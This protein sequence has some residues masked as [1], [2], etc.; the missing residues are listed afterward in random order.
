MR[1]ALFVATVIVFVTAIVFQ[2]PAAVDSKTNAGDL[3]ASTMYPSEIAA[4]DDLVD[5]VL[6]ARDFARSVERETAFLEFDNKTGRFVR[7]QLY[8]YAYDFQGTNLA[9]PF[10]PDF[11][12]RNKSNL[13]DPNGVAFIRDLADN[14]RKGT[15]F[16]YFIFPNPDHGGKDELKIGYVAKVDDSWWLGSGIYLSEVPAF[17]SPDARNDLVFF[18]NEALNYTQKNGKDKAIEAFND[19]NGSFVRGNLY[20]YAYDTNGT[21]LALP[22]QPELVSKSRLLAEDPN[23]V[24]FI[25]NLID[26]AKR[27][28][29]Y[30]YYLYPDPSENMTERLK[31]S[32]VRKVNDHWFLGAGIYG[33]EPKAENAAPGSYLGEIAKITKEK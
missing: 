8:I 15:G 31:L 16:T 7:G 32:Y 1:A 14:A 20:I 22:F 6:K 30:A 27:G 24:R 26:Q 9:H 3:P 5:F 13:T 18:V 25:Q 12:G 19:R 23:S 29:G 11:I 10:R 2:I 17:F 4:K 28:R 21:T 33:A